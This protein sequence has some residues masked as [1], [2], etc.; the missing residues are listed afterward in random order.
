MSRSFCSVLLPQRRR[1]FPFCA[2]FSTE[3]PACLASKFS[4]RARPSKPAVC[5]D[6][7]TKLGLHSFFIAV[8]SLC[9][10]ASRGKFARKFSFHNCFFWLFIF[11]TRYIFKRIIET[12]SFETTTSQCLR[13]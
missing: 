1:F 6:K 12:V 5:L 8:S 2:K 13:F 9:V 4:A 7:S 10:R 3:N 11:S